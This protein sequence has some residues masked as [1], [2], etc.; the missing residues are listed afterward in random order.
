MENESV[1]L[2]RDDLSK[3]LDRPSCAGMIGHVAVSNLTCSYLHDYKHVENS[4]ASCHEDK[5]IAG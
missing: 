4:K 1:G 2:I 5:E 3:L